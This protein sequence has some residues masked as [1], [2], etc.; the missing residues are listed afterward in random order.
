MIDNSQKYWDAKYLNENQDLINS[1]K[2]IQPKGDFIFDDVNGIK[3]RF[4]DS[5]I[6]NGGK[7]LDIGCGI[8]G[9]TKQI[10]LL[11][12]DCEVYGIDFSEVA[13]NINRNKIPNINFLCQDVDKEISLPNNFFD[14]VFIRHVLEYVESPDLFV[15]EAMRVLKPNGLA[16]IVTMFLANRSPEYNNFFTTDNLPMLFFDYSTQ[17]DVFHAVNP[18][19]WNATIFMLKNKEIY[20][21]SIHGYL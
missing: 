14:A 4:P 7:I 18:K 11:K 2:I 21:E 6:P 10:K 8:G 19:C 1:D 5:L 13:I 17:M 3:R 16:Y 12:P 9:F 15:K 20:N